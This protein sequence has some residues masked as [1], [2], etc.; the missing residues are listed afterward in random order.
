MVKCTYC[1]KTIERYEQHQNFIGAYTCSKDS[2]VNKR[3]TTLY[4]QTSAQ[5]AEKIIQQ[6]RMIPGLYGLAGPAIYFA[7]LPEHTHH[8]ARSYGVILECEVDL[9]PIWTIDTSGNYSLTK[10]EV[11]KRGYGSV[12]IPRLN[13]NEY[14]VYDSSRVKSFKIIS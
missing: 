8:K 10:E 11:N 12:C 1:L 13:G 4:H 6:K 5:A 2:S 7:E 9:E 14:A 3:T